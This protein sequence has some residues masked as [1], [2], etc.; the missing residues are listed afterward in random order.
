MGRWLATAIDPLRA[1]PGLGAAVKL[2]RPD[3]IPVADDES[4]IHATSA[5]AVQAHSLAVVIV[6]L[7]TPPLAATFWLNGATS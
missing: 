5:T 7:P 1:S 4:I 2:M 6:M 3:P